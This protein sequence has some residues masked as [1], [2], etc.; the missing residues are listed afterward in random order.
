MKGTPDII[1]W[2]V[3]LVLILGLAPNAYGKRAKTRTKTT[4]VKVRK[5]HLKKSIN[6]AVDRSDKEQKRIKVR[7]DDEADER[8]ESWTIRQKDVIEIKHT[9]TS[10]IEPVNLG[11]ANLTEEEVG[12]DQSGL[13][14]LRQEVNDEP[15]DIDF[16]KELREV[17]SLKD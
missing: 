12:E 14:S 1:R 10:S 7:F 16:D 15:T 17:S 5:N 6:D 2:I 9:G 13:D 8:V 3:M 11:E 4:K